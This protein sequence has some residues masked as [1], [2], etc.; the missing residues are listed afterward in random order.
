MSPRVELPFIDSVRE[1]D[2]HGGRHQSLDRPWKAYWPP[3]EGGEL[4]KLLQETV[5][6]AL[7][8]RFNP[9]D[10]FDR[11]WQSW[12][13]QAILSGRVCTSKV[14]LPTK[15]A[16]VEPDKNGYHEFTELTSNPLHRK[17]CL[18]RQ[19]GTLQVDEIISNLGLQFVSPAQF[20]YLSPDPLYDTVKPYHTRLP[21]MGEIKR[22][23]II[24]QGY[25][26]VNIF[27]VA[28]FDDKFTLEKSGFQYLRIKHGMDEWT[29]DAVKKKYL[30]AMEEW[31]Q[32]FFQCRKVHIYTYTVSE[33]PAKPIYHLSLLLLI[34]FKFR[35]AD[36]DRTA[37]ESWVGPYMRA[38]CG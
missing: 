26:N 27:N 25:D 6:E 17:N 38:H 13:R 37:T 34:I 14:L 4:H 15:S 12:S 32:S 33:I 5:P 21:F 7:S 30:P 22:A 20:N 19:R 31:L 29:D 9:K 16:P 36:R 35:C 18:A 23:N 8:W 11:P 28:G 24:G 10:P 2:Q 1:V 3:E